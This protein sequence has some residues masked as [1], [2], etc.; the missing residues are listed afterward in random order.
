MCNVAG[1]TGQNQEHVRTDAELLLAIEEIL[2]GMAVNNDTEMLTQLEDA[3]QCACDETDEENIGASRFE[4]AARASRK[5]SNGIQREL[6]GRSLVQCYNEWCETPYSPSTGVACKD[7]CLLFGENEQGA[8]I[9]YVDKDPK[10]TIYIYLPHNL[11]DPLEA[12]VKEAVETFYSTSF[13]GN[14]AALRAICAAM[15]LVLEGQNINRIFWT[16]GPGG[17]GQSLLSHHLHAVFAAL[18]AFVDTTVFYSDDEMRKQ[19]EHLINKLVMTCQEAVE[20][21]RHG[22]R[23]DIYKKNCKCRSAGSTTAICNRD[24]FSGDN[25]VEKV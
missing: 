10:H 21:S 3:T 15:C 17:V 11:K 20:N 22:M 25:W 4:N 18:H 16:I 1:G 24:A 5:L 23:Q 13:F 12:S 7:S 14:K 9:T 8:L 19:A 2:E 6:M